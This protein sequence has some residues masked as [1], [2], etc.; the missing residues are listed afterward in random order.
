MFGM[1]NART[2][3]KNIDGICS[4]LKRKTPIDDYCFSGVFKSDEIKKK[5]E[6]AEFEKQYKQYVIAKKKF[7]KLE[8]K[9]IKKRDW[10]LMNL[11]LASIDTAIDDIEE[12]GEE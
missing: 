5:I 7:K 1:S 3:K 4:M 2:A 10:H 9:I 12:E 8:A 6:D 11:L